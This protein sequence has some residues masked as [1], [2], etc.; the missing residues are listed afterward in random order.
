MSKV[1]RPLVFGGTAMVGLFLSSSLLLAAPAQVPVPVSTNF[2]LPAP[3]Y[4]AQ[5]NGSGREALLK[6][7][8]IEKKAEV[9]VAAVKV[10][11]QPTV[12]PKV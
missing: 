8:G 1:N 2:K 4:V 7:L 5:V 3:A 6:N 9:K 11:V 10:A 12:D